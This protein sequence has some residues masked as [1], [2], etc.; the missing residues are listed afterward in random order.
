M[1][2]CMARGGNGCFALGK[3]FR[4]VQKRP[5]SM[6][7]VV[8]ISRV[9]EACLGIPLTTGQVFETTLMI[10]TDESH[11]RFVAHMLFFRFF[12]IGCG[13]TGVCILKS[14]YEELHSLVCSDGF[15]HGAGSS[16]RLLLT[17]LQLRTLQ[18]SRRV[19]LSMLG[20]L[21][22]LRAVDLCAARLAD[23]PLGPLGQGMLVVHYCLLVLNMLLLSTASM[24]FHWH[25]RHHEIVGLTLNG[26]T[27]LSS[28]LASKQHTVH[29]DLDG[30][31]RR[32]DRASE[33]QCCICLCR[34]GEG[35]VV[36]TLPCCHSFHRACLEP[37]LRQ[38][39]GCPLRCPGHVEAAPGSRSSASPASLVALPGDEPFELPLDEP[40]FSV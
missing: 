19:L 21:L 14:I 9:A 6:A 16:R 25:W 2:T 31:S 38:G 12:I 13:V 32:L 11:M 40:V 28:A 10:S 18:R 36:S 5:K 23:L 29:V 20:L 3:F 4:D 26:G 1:L 7:D 24:V 17:E 34:L 35:D 30:C 37:W 8:W 39:H 27:V 15:G 22:F 33:E